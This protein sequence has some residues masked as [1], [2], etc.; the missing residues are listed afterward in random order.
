[1]ST[2]GLERFDAFAGLRTRLGALAD[3][4]GEWAGIPM[5]LDGHPLVIEP[6]FPGRSVL[7]PPEQEPPSDVKP[8]ACFWSTYRRCDILIWED[9]RGKI[10]CGLIP[11]MH[12]FAQ[13]LQTVGASAAWG[14]EQEARAIQLLATKLSH[15]AFVRYMLTGMFLETSERSGITY[16]FRRLRP[17]VAITTRNDSVR[18]LCALCMHPIAYYARSWAGAMCPTADV[19]AHLMMMRGDEHMYW[20][21]CNQ[22]P[23]WRPEAGL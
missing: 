16:A 1:V 6:T 15:Y 2:E 13:D 5:P 10:E 11:G 22:H 18:I 17:T 9:R 19:I 12:H 20:R 8:R 21:R 7:A 14:V 23:S 4:A 3:L